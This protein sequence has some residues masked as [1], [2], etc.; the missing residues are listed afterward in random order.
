MRITEELAK[1]IIHQQE[2]VHHWYPMTT[3]RGEHWTPYHDADFNLLSVD[4]LVF[5]FYDLGTRRVPSF[6]IGY[7]NFQLGEWHTLANGVPFTA[8]CWRYLDE[9]PVSVPERET[10]G[11]SRAPLDAPGDTER[12][13]N[14]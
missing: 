3:D 11:D 8:L 13:V 14:Q 1:K 7:Y 9:Y 12:A 6:A 5:G 4:V 2:V 10:P